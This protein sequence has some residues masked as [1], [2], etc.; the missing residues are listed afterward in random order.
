MIVIGGSLGGMKVVR[1]LLRGLPASFPGPI[2]IALHRHREADDHD[3]LVHLIQQESALPVSEP[4]DKE[5]ISPNH[6]YVAPPDYHLLVERENFS[7]STDDPV[8]YAR[9]SIDVL[10]ESAADAFGASLIGIILTG[11]NRD[12]ARGAAA[13]QEKGGMILVQDPATAESEVMPRAAIEATGTLHV[14]PPDRLGEMLLRL[15]GTP[16]PTPS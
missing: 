12:G 11:A 13:I 6:V 10:F 1:T 2:A 9:P 4:L 7:L 3:L 5:P 15:T 8:Q 14:Y 16:V